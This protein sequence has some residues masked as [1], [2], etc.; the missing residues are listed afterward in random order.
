M[1]KDY[2]NVLEKEVIREMAWGI[3]A[4]ISKVRNVIGENK[5]L[6]EL[7][8]NFGDKIESLPNMTFEKVQELEVIIKFLRKVLK[9]TKE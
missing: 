5:L 8:K 6:K 2:E 9:E 3:L 4:E 7:E 1:K